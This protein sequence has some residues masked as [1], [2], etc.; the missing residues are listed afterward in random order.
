[1]V[2]RRYEDTPYEDLCQ[3]LGMSL[4]AV[5]SLLFRARMELR[6]SLSAYLEDDMG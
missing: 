1:M 2:L 4:P 6:K 5:K 3:I